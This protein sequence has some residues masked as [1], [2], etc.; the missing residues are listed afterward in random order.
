M[1]TQIADHFGFGVAL[2]DSPQVPSKNK[3]DMDALIQQGMITVKQDYY[4]L[5]CQKVHVLDL[6][7][8]DFISI[9]NRANWLYGCP[10]LEEGD[11]DLFDSLPADEP[12]EGVTSIEESFYQ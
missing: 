8:Y 7:T 5:M 12:M 11:E 2:A 9:T 1:I 10:D 6:S 4:S 3:L